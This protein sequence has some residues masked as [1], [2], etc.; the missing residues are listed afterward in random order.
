MR[1]VDDVSGGPSGKTAIY[2]RE[3]QRTRTVQYIVFENRCRTPARARGEEFGAH[4]EASPLLTI[5]R[6]AVALP[7]NAR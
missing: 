5:R 2:I 4:D 6:V 1:A 7:A 3:S